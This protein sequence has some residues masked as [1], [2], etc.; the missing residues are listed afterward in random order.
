MSENTK[1]TKNTLIEAENVALRAELDEANRKIKAIETGNR[2]DAEL[3]K[4]VAALTKSLAAAEKR[5]AALSANQLTAKQIEK[6]NGYGRLSASLR[7][8]AIELGNLTSKCNRANA[9]LRQFEDGFKD[10]DE[11]I[12]R[13]AVGEARAIGSAKKFRNRMRIGLVS[14]AL[15]TAA[16]AGGGY[17]YVEMELTPPEQL[18]AEARDA[19]IKNAP[20]YRK[21]I[22]EA[23]A[24]ERERLRVD[25]DSLTEAEIN[26]ERDKPGWF[27][28]YSMPVIYVICGI[29]VG[30]FIALGT[31]LKL[32]R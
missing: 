32:F 8:Q 19:F 1:N 5:S 15:F 6:I 7:E 31:A 21:V 13:L 10:K 30:F 23:T 2:R 29:V 26:F 24:N 12:E 14:A 17:Y 25:R 9:E 22:A 3:G 11:R 28:T 18:S 16:V 27:S 20:E 4:T